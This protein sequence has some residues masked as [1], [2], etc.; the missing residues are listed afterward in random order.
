[1]PQSACDGEEDQNFITA[2]KM[3]TILEIEGSENYTQNFQ[4]SPY[5]DFPFSNS[6]SRV[7]MATTG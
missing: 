2:R 7:T 3:D 4:K 6:K 5:N 1:L